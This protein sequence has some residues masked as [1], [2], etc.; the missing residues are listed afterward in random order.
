[1]ALPSGLTCQISPGTA[2]PRRLR[3]PIGGD[4]E[5]LWSQRE[6]ARPAHADHPGIEHL[7]LRAQPEHDPLRAVG[8]IDVAGGVGDRALRLLERRREFRAAACRP[9]GSSARPASMR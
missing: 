4:P 8:D 7:A 2:L 9:R 3:R 5:L 1:M 6:Q